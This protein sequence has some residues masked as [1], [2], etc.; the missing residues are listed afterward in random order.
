MRRV[1]RSRISA[2]SA[3]NASGRSCRARAATRS[4]S[5]REPRLQACGQRAHPLPPHTHARAHLSSRARQ[6]AAH[7]L[8]NSM[9]RGTP[10][11]AAFPGRS[12]ATTAVDRQGVHSARTRKARPDAR[13]QT[14]A[15]AMGGLASHSAQVAHVIPRPSR[16][17]AAPPLVRVRLAPN[18]NERR[19][20]R[21]G[22]SASADELGGAAIDARCDGCEGPADTGGRPLKLRRGPKMPASLR[23]P[24]APDAFCD[25]SDVAVSDTAER[26]R[27]ALLAEHGISDW[28]DRIARTRARVDGVHTGRLRRA[29]VGRCR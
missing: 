23:N 17:N 24:R 2:C 19:K 27:I 18:V 9:R 5:V 15:H 13:T 20:S 29:A 12:T 3:R 28:H 14:G 26:R 25:P 21:R 8:K 10:A 22:D 1:S 16:L 7:T 4:S 6:A 11:S